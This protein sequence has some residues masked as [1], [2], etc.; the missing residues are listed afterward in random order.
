MGEVAMANVLDFDILVNEFKLQS[1]Y[2]VHF[3]PNNFK[4]GIISPA[5]G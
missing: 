2:N 3:L 4:K 1:R 5:M